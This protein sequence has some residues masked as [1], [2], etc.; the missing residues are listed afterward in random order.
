[1]LAV[2]PVLAKAIT[3]VPTLA[4]WLKVTLSLERSIRNAASLLELSVQLTSISLVEIALAVRP[5]GAAGRAEVVAL[6][7]TLV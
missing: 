3:F 2:S 1:V 5:V 4:I 7:A 6:L